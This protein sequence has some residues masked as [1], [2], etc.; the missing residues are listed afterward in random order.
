MN[1]IKFNLYDN[2]GYILV[3]LYQIIFCYLLLLFVKNQPID[4]TLFT[5]TGA[6]FSILLLSYFVGHLIQALSNFVDD[7][8]IAKIVKKFFK[9]ARNEED[10]KLTKNNDL[11]FITK[12]ARKFFDLPENLNEKYV[13]QYCYLFALSYDFSGHISLFNSMYSLYRGFFVSS[14]LTLFAYVTILIKALFS[15]D[16]SLKSNAPFYLLFFLLSLFTWLFY[17]RK[18]RFFKYMNDKTLITYDILSKGK[19]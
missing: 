11:E 12:Q 13:F 18:E 2:L 3:G 10:R 4:L 5:S 1:N 17:A 7:V 16:M 6:S 15:N 9:K 19:R 14:L 8:L